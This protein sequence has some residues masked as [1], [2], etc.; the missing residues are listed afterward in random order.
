M[1]AWVELRKKHQEET[2]AFPIHFAFGQE[3]IDRIMAELH[4]DPEH[5]SEQIVTVGAGGF[6]LKEDAP[7]LKE[8]WKRHEDERAKC[9]AEDDTGDGFIYDMFRYEL[10]N[11]EYGY[12]GFV[13]ETLEYL[14]YTMEDIQADKR[15]LHGLQKA[16]TD[17]MKKEAMGA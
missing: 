14:G 7:K 12:T 4:L 2:N 8:M 13:D 11:H 17:I 5:L 15:L 3:Q 9:I 1:N 6:V 10:A 16:A